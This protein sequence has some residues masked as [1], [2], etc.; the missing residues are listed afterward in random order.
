M[1]PRESLGLGRAETMKILAFDT[2]TKYLSI[3]CLEDS[4][5]RLEFHEDVGIQ[6]SEILIPTIK[7]TLEKLNWTI[8]D[9]EL[10]CVGLG[11]GSF[12]GLRIALATVKGMALVLHNKVV[13]V[14]SMDAI[15]MNLPRGKY[16]LAAPFL[17]ARKE[18]VYTC[19]Y[20]V[21]DEEPKRTT[22]YLLT[23]ADEFLSNLKKE[24]FFL[25]DAVTK[26]KEKLDQYP[27]AFYQEDINWHPKASEIG[28]IGFKKS[29]T[30]TDD[31]ERLNPLYL[32]TK[33]CNIVQRSK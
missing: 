30:K 22:D 29:L 5:V 23:T 9:V 25:G 13:G 3:A 14:P 2:S 20:D 19:I 27:L 17:D 11:P 26:Y 16:T 8:K 7:S 12:T 28:R 33:E 1:L 24:V 15:I 4:N 21:S 18:K 32:H 31:P 10:V 6:H